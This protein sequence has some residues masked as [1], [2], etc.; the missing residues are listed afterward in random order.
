MVHSAQVKVLPFVMSF[1]QVHVRLSSIEFLAGLNALSWA[2][3]VRVEQ[4]E[5][6]VIIEIK[7]LLPILV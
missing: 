4:F 3:P 7:V 6:R 1:W 2:L 5:T